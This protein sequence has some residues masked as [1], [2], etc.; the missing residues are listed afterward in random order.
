M[1]FKFYEN[2]WIPG[3]K[4]VFYLIF[5]LF[6]FIKGSTLETT[7]IFFDVLIILIAII[8][9]AIGFLTKG[10]KNKIWIIIAGMIHLGF[11]IWLTLNWGNE[12]IHLLWIITLWIIY[13]ALT[14]LVEALILYA[15]K[16]VLGTLFIINMIATLVF[17]YFTMMLHQNYSP[18]TL[19]Y[20]GIVAIMAG[21]ITEGSGFIISQ[22]R[23]IAE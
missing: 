9:L 4:G 1:K 16:N 17:A 19:Q 3:I 7:S 13:S 15:S 2:A 12:S 8:Y 23:F 10:I 6:A 22:S 20:L 11:G 14:D 5:G 21:L 18:D